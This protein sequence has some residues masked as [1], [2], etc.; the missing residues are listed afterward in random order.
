MLSALSAS[1]LSD[2]ISHGLRIL[3]EV[4]CA[5]VDACGTPTWSVDF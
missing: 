3:E 4:L 1:V 2:D 5:R